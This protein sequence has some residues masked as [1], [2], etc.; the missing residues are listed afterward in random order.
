VDGLV[1]AHGFDHQLE[2]ATVRHLQ[3]GKGRHG[4]RIAALVSTSAAVATFAVASPAHATHP[5]EAGTT[6]ASVPDPVYLPSVDQQT[7][8]LLAELHREQNLNE[9][10]LIHNELVLLYRDRG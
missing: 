3:Q 7:R 5:V 2:E 4:V 10:R 1:Q 8:I 6:H 9:R